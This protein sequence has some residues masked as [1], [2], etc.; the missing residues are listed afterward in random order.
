MGARSRFSVVVALAGAS[1][2]LGPQ[3]IHLHLLPA[4]PPP[5]RCTVSGVLPVRFA[6]V[7]ERRFRDHCG[8][9]VYGPYQNRSV[10]VPDRPIVEA[11]TQ[12]LDVRAAELGFSVAADGIPI[13]VSVHEVFNRFAP[14]MTEM[15]SEG[16][17]RL[18][19]RIK[20]GERLRYIKVVDGYGH[21]ADAVGFADLAE[22]TLNL[23]LTD[24]V[25][26]L[27][28]DPAFVAALR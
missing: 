28:C 13:E 20:V 9:D 23:G 10:Y 1:C 17:V 6:V 19:A 5:D 8:A 22:R 24:A 7:D 11:V 27:L 16:T 3:P 18:V 2:V 4:L 12:A 26:T 15:H 25:T 21:R 14:S